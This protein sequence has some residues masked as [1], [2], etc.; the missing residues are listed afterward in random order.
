MLYQDGEGQLAQVGG[1]MDRLDNTRYLDSLRALHQSVPCWKRLHGKTIFISGVSGMLGTYLT[2]AIMLRNEDLPA[3]ERCRIIGAGR[4]RDAAQAR[5]GRWLS[6]GTFTFIE[7]NIDLPMEQ[8]PAA[9]DYCIHAASTTHPVAYASEPINTVLSNVLGARNL[10][11]LASRKKSCRFLL[12]S[13]VEIYGEN[14]G[15]TEYFSENYCGYMDCNTLRAGYPE[16]KRVSEALCQAYSAEKDVDTVIL[17]LPR[18]Y[19]P[20]MRR[21][22]TK[23]VAQ[24][25]KKA[26]EGE[27]IV[28]KSAGGQLYSYAHVSDAVSGI[29]WTLLCGERGQAYN[30]ADKRSDIT[31]RELAACAAACVERNV[32]FHLPE[33]QERIGYSTA[34]KAILNAEKLRKLGWQANYD[35]EAGIRETISILK[36]TGIGEN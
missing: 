22:D 31:L 12:L 21:S 4:S 19:G 6:S 25:I 14:R 8:I 10:L 3:G 9:P 18:C 20:T 33:E 36:E 5:F 23:A 30:L 29:L 1:H 34:S 28:L 11:E 2:D 32:V 17:R 16:A 15:D 7:H 13:S 27:D 24:F 26:V 35:I